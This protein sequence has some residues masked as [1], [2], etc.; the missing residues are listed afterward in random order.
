MK[1]QI[2]KKN[3]TEESR[4][5]LKK[6]KTDLYFSTFHDTL[7]FEQWASHFYFK[8]GLAKN[9]AR[10]PRGPWSVMAPI[11]GDMQIAMS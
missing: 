9:M 10:S 1:Y 5:R 8:T 3:K 7:P 6:K 11:V 2:K 4:G